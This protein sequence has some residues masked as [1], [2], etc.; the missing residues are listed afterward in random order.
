MIPAPVRSTSHS[1]LDVFTILKNNGPF[2]TDM[3]TVEAYYFAKAHKLVAYDHF[4]AYWNDGRSK[5]ILRDVLAAH[6]PPLKYCHTME[7]GF[8]GLDVYVAV[9]KE[10]FGAQHEAP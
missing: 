2:P 4:M 3:C 1:M 9:A 10:V 5:Q 6:Y 7:E 8:V